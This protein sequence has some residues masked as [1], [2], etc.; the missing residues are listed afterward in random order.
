MYRGVF[1][2]Q[3]GTDGQFPW[4]ENRDLQNLKTRIGAFNSI[5][6]Y[7]KSFIQNRSTFYCLTKQR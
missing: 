1:E 2:K 3:R 7:H 4:R 5:T 6:I